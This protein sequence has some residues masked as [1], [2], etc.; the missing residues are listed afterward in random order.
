MINKN[1]YEEPKKLEVR[2]RLMFLDDV[3]LPFE[4]FSYTTML[5]VLKDEVPQSD[6]PVYYVFKI[7]NEKPAFSFVLLT[8]SPLGEEITKTMGTEVDEGNGVYLQCV[9]GRVQVIL[10]AEDKA[11]S[12][13][14][15]LR[16]N[17]EE[18]E[19]TIVPKGFGYVLI[20]KNIED[21]IVAQ[22]HFG[23]ET[24]Y[25]FIKNRGAAVYLTN[26][27]YVLNANYIVKRIV[28]ADPTKLKEYYKAPSLDLFKAF[29]L[30]PESFD[31]LK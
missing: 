24:N 5:P 18:G 11:S 12:A 9:L 25:T 31:F 19:S 17:L 26:Y 3:S 15:V 27:G 4:A 22:L 28:D 29:Y 16:L 23:K 13:F 20:N 1:L 10:Q 14:N 6:K 21:S 2:G 30:H 8:N 7:K